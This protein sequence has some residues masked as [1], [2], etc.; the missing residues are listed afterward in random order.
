MKAV[1]STVYEASELREQHPSGFERALDRYRNTYWDVFGQESV[2]D[3]M[4]MRADQYGFPTSREFFYDLYGRQ[5]SGFA[6]GPLT[7][8]EDAALGKVFPDLEGIGV[9]FEDGRLVAWGDW[10]EDGTTYQKEVASEW[11]DELYEA[12]LEAGRDEMDNLESA[13]YFVEHAELNEWMFEQDGS[14]R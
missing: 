8:E 13:D 9:S 1:T 3:F 14:L 12:M 6:G 2:Q 7:D 4:R 10:D 11:L 5:A